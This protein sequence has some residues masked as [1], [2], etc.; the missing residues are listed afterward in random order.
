MSSHVNQPPTV[1]RPFF[2]RHHEASLITLPCPQT[3]VTCRQESEPVSSSQLNQ[4]LPFAPAVD[5]QQLLSTAARVPQSQKTSPG[6]APPYNNQPDPGDSIRQQDLVLWVTS[7]LQHIP[8][9]ED[10]PVT[11]STG[12]AIGFWLRPFNF[13]DENAA[14]SQPDL[15][16]IPA[17]TMKQANAS[18]Q[19]ADGNDAAF[20]MGTL[21]AQAITGERS[22]SSDNTTNR[23]G[24]RGGP[25]LAQVGRDTADVVTMVGMGSLTAARRGIQPYVGLTLTQTCIPLTPSVP[26]NSSYG[27]LMSNR[28]LKAGAAAAPAPA[29]SSNQG[30]G[31]DGS[32]SGTSGGAA[33]RSAGT[34]SST[35]DSSSSSS[36]S[37][38]GDRR[39]VSG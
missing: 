34:T 29:S 20:A 5:F 25:L 11:P 27:A 24:A 22:S 32:I 15:V 13:F 9:A 16:Y 21:L 14:A 31:H 10:A 7:G 17:L 19:A 35:D 28:S 18:V 12:P 6:A 33:G 3:A 4:A 37:D 1:C 39:A 2:R 30:T 26:W 8:G 36:S 23:G 38:D